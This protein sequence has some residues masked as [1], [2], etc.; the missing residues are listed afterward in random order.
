MMKNKKGSKEALAWGAKMKAMRM[1]KKGGMIRKHYDSESDSEIESGEGLFDDIGTV[2]NSSYNLGHDVIGPAIFGRGKKKELH[3]EH[4]HN[5]A[6]Q[7]MKQMNPF[8]NFKQALRK[9]IHNVSGFDIGEGIKHRRV[10]IGKH[11]MVGGAYTNWAGDAPSVP[12]GFAGNTNNGMM[13]V[14]MAHSL[15]QVHIAG[16]GVIDQGFNNGGIAEQYNQRNLG[17]NGRVIL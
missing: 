2:W 7:L 13:R 14:P 16:E 1:K 15:H 12:V 9:G 10:R 17:A 4:A 6:L 11:R 8:Y 3:Y 5:P